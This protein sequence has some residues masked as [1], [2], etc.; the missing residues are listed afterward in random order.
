[1]QSLRNNFLTGLIVVAPIGITIFLTWTIIDYVDQQV[2]PQVLPLLPEE[3]HPDN[4]L[5]FYLPGLGLLV[6]ILFLTFV[7]GLAKNFFG[8]EL[9]R[10]GESWVDRMPVVRSVYNALKQITETI[11]ADSAASFDKACLIEYPRRGVWAIAF[12]ATDTKGEVRERAAGEGEMVSVFL[13]TTPNPTSGFLLFVPKE[14]VIIL[15]MTLEEAAKLVISGGLITPPHRTVEEGALVA[16]GAGDSGASETP[17]L[18]E[19][20]GE[21]DA[22]APMRAASPRSFSKRF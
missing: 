5:P 21:R 11:F 10:I 12:V 2:L 20:I 7:G 14:D 4:F 18:T 3:Y 9:I 16:N 6:F 15:D 8:R 1:M 22:A 19:A 17:A 13:P